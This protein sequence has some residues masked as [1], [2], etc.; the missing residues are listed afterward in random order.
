MGRAQWD[1]RPWVITFGRV[2]EKLN[3]QVRRNFSWWFKGQQAALYRAVPVVT[4]PSPVAGDH[5]PVLVV[6]VAL[7][8]LWVQGSKGKKFCLIETKKNL[9]K[10]VGASQEQ[11]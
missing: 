2:T 7:L 6:R 4:S 9:V 11:W 1:H 5:W 3:P 8:T 10:E